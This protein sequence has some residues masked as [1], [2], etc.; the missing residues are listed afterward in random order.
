MFL[1]SLK[2]RTYMVIKCRKKNNIVKYWPMPKNGKT[3]LFQ[4]YI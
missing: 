4:I 2:T 1:G 3:L